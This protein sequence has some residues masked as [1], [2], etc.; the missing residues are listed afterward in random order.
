MKAIRQWVDGNG[1]MLVD[2]LR[3]PASVGAELELKGIQFEVQE[4][5]ASSF[6]HPISTGSSRNAF[7]SM[8]AKSAEPQLPAEGKATDIKT[9]L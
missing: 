3:L 7:D 5:D 6:G 1:T 4:N 9:G 8:M 2:S